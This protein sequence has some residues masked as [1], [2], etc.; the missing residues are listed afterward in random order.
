MGLL[1]LDCG[2]SRLGPESDRPS[3]DHFWRRLIVGVTS[4]IEGASSGMI[5]GSLCTCL[6]MSRSGDGTCSLLPACRFPSS[7]TPASSCEVCSCRASGVCTSPRKANSGGRFCLQNSA[8]GTFAF[9]STQQQESR[10]PRGPL[11]SKRFWLTFRQQVPAGWSSRA[12]AVHRTRS[13]FV[14]SLERSTPIAPSGQ[15]STTT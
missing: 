8:V 11:R 5:V 3:D 6:S 7:A 15:W 10:L 4:T 2:R 14:R 1:A 9:A 13:T 12:E